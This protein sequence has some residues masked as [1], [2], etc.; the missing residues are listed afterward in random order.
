MV[1]VRGRKL[2]IACIFKGER[3]SRSYLQEHIIPNIDDAEAASPTMV[4]AFAKKAKTGDKA[5]A[6]TTS[7]KRSQRFPT[8]TAADL[9]SDAKLLACFKAATV[10]R[11]P[12][13]RDTYTDRLNVFAAAERA[14]EVGDDPPA[15]FAHIV[16]RKQWEL[17]SDAQEGRAL[18]RLRR[19]RN[20]QREA[21]RRRPRDDGQPPSE[22]AAVGDVLCEFLKATCSKTSS[23]R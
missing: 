17:I 21:E 11:N 5:R 10:Q 20:P 23:C 16:G 18:S 3:S 7:S 2:V 12:I 8:L 9:R 19:L 1:I 4:F 14:L 13:V 6:K 15:L 22:P